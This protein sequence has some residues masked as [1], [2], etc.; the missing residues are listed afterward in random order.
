MN[1]KRI[2]LSAA[3]ALSAGLAVIAALAGFSDSTPIRLIQG[4]AFLVLLIFGI[5]GA[6]GAVGA[7]VAR[8]AAAGPRFAPSCP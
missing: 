8:S 7:T 5:G 3:V 2:L 1:A 6:M 4:A